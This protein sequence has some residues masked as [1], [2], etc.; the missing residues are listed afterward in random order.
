[1]LEGLV[2]VR[3]MSLDASASS[4]FEG[5]AALLVVPS[6]RLDW[7]KLP[8]FRSMFEAARENGVPIVYWDG[9]DTNTSDG[10]VLAQ[11]AD[12]IFTWSSERITFYE[13]SCV[14]AT[15]IQVLKNGVNP[16]HY[17][18]VGAGGNRE[19]FVIYNPGVLPGTGESRQYL[20]WVLE[21]LMKSK[22]ALLITE[23]SFESPIRSTAPYMVSKE[24][25]VHLDRI[26]RLSDF[27][28]VENAIM[29]SQEDFS[30]DVVDQMAMGKLVL[31]TYSQGVNSHHPY[32]HIAN[33]SDDVASTLD[34]LSSRELL[35]AQ[36]AGVREA[37]T[38]HHAYDRV[39]TILA[40]LG[41]V[42][43]ESAKERVL[44]VSKE[45]S[46]A[47][48]QNMSVQTCGMVPVIDWNELS[49]YRDEY[50]VL[51][52]LNPAWHYSPTY[53]Q[54]HVAAFSYQ[55]SNVTMKLD[56]APSDAVDRRHQFTDALTA[57]EM[58]AWW[59]PD[60]RYLSS[61]E[62][63]SSSFDNA[64]AIDQE[65]FSRSRDRI[66]VDPGRKLHLDDEARLKESASAFS[67][68][69]KR[70]NLELSV[71][72]PIYNNGDHL[73]HKCFAS[74]VRS[75]IFNK[76]QI[77]LVND[78]SSDPQTIETIDQLARTYENVEAFHFPKG[79]SGSASRP[80][81]A[82]LQLASTPYV[83]YLDPDN[84]ATEDGYAKLLEDLKAYGEAQFAVGNISVW[85]HRY[86]P[87]RYHQRLLDAFGDD[88][89][90]N[91]TVH[92]PHHAIA[93]VDFRPISIQ[94]AVIRTA[95]LKSLGL[96]QPLGAVGQDTFFFQQM[97]HYADRIRIHDTSVHTYYGVVANSTVNDI[98]PRFFEKYVPLERARS[99]WV[100]SVGLLEEYQ[101][102]RLER[103]L[104]TWH[105]VKLERVSDE[106]WLEAAETIAEFTS[107]YEKSTWNSRGVR[108]FFAR[109]EKERTRV[110]SPLNAPADEPVQSPVR[111]EDIER[112]GANLPLLIYSSLRRLNFHA[113]FG[114]MKYRTDLSE[115]STLDSLLINKDSETLV[116]AFHGALTSG[117]KELPHFEWL[118]TLQNTEYSSLFVSDPTLYMSK[119]LNLAWY[120][121]SESLDLRPI[122]AQLVRKA[123]AATGA[124]NIILTGSSGGGFAS[125][126]VGAYLPDSL[127]LAYNPQTDVRRYHWTVQ[128]RLRK[129]IFPQLSDG[130]DRV[131]DSWTLSLGTRTSVLRRYQQNP[132]NEFWVVQNM[133]DQHHVTEH[134]RPFR[135]QVES[136]A[137]N[138]DSRF[139]EYPGPHGHYPP[140]RELFLGLLEDGV[141]RLRQKGV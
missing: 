95:W 31:S 67:V 14:N 127:S 62:R 113:S 27:S 115:G 73:R 93:R 34:S 129:R 33:S 38:D 108:N 135:E 82:G 138:N 125:L 123:A 130:R 64:Y 30:P 20:A 44:G 3:R 105:L 23:G 76:M 133:N 71:I 11:Y 110:G 2:A 72:V 19:E 61:P 91:G 51:L 106:E 101:N 55:G 32:V 103:F 4:D 109:L 92:L 56:C 94:A 80:R 39:T 86:V 60:E 12:H 132:Q 126:Q 136:S 84:E 128:E 43:S 26:S 45:P 139:I 70:L 28:I 140:N 111:A 8:A 99:E 35:A 68:A 50:D 10:Q 53:V 88:M 107:Y 122:L 29:A 96:E 52:P 77:L 63:L 46:D 78:G 5:M 89:D 21:G 37:F 48:R 97:L 118:R 65:G 36:N 41:L 15:T 47:L 49:E 116:V 9:A 59:K 16:L 141:A 85:R 25:A 117:K 54:D 114:A 121:G 66:N 134:Y 131:R 90:Q 40:T 22:K 79:G 75:S 1:M 18:P 98:S 102:T 7:M 100:K 81:N 83:T 6:E 24:F 74:L 42:E 119:G 87:Q 137:T 120:I 104:R 57:L 58:T 112:S 17:S 69:G 124:K 13:N